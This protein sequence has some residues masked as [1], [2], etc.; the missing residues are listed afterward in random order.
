MTRDPKPAAV[1]AAPQKPG[2]YYGYIIV[3]CSFL[4]LMLC[5]G[6]NYSFGTFFN[7][8][9][10]DF[11]WN[12]AVT[13]LGYSVS[14]FVGGTMG[15]CTG[16]FTDRFGPRPALIVSGA[17]MALGCFL[18][19]RVNHPWQLYV[20]YGLFVG[21]GFGGAFIP[22]MTSISR[23]F[24]RRR[25]LMTGIA[26]SGSGFGTI[27]M[28]LVAT[29]LLSHF[30]W[31][32]SFMIISAL[33]LAITV[34]AALLYKRDPSKVHQ[35]APGSGETAVSPQASPVEGLTFKEAALTARF[36]IVCIIFFFFG[37][38]IQAIMLH[39]VPY[40]KNLG[41]SPGN[42][43]L[44]LSF[45]GVGSVLGRIGIGGMSDRIGVK[46]SLIIVFAIAVLTFGWLQMSGDLWMLFV[47]GAFFGFAYGGTIAL[48]SLLGARLFGLTALSTIVG[49]MVFA[50]T[51]G[52]A[53]GS[54]LTGYIFDVS[55]AYSLA[56]RIAMGLS[57]A[58]L[59]L[60]CLL[61]VQAKKPGE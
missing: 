20:F 53:I 45:S 22:A 6:I 60:A 36:W 25:G 38:F 42:A 44:I 47:F 11:G 23:W 59:A 13:S 3:A 19:S 37:Y 17:S 14:Q 50:Y 4:I 52:G 57:V 49:V 46:Y 1:T 29:G 24:V 34:P 35:V 39:I 40:A 43:A 61:R 55:G 21:I 33:A 12:R 18:M 31:R 5:F 9:L 32:I 28:P 27:I 41:I 8:L 48:E 54:V 51:S 58:A 56:F 16:R 10:Q 26:V 15:I 7:A 2:F 30:N